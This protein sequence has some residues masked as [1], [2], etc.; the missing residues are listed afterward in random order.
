M[1]MLTE[2]RGHQGRGPRRHAGDV[3]IRV[4]GQG[5][6]SRQDGPRP[7]RSRRQ[8]KAL[9]MLHAVKAGFLTHLLDLSLIQ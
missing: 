6:Q 1:W 7:A 4:H 2:P 3:E 9:R 8:S 5:P